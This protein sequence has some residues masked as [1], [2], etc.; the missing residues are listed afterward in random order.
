MSLRQL[1]IGAAAGSSGRMRIAADSRR[2]RW[3]AASVALGAAAVLL[4]TVNPSTPFVSDLNLRL[5]DRLLRETTKERLPAEFLLVGLD[6]ASL[7]LDTVEPEEIAQSRALQLMSQ[8]FPWSREVYA[9]VG[10]KL[11]EAGAKLVIFDMVYPGPNPGDGVFADFLRN[12][13]G[14]VVLGSLFEK[15]SAPHQP[16]T[17]RA[18]TA[19]LAAAAG[20]FIG[21]ASLTDQGE[22]RH[23]MPFAS[24]SDFMGEPGYPDE[25]V[26]RALTT[27]A[28]AALGKTFPAAIRRPLRFRYSVP[29]RVETVSL[30][31][32]FV[33]GYW[34]TNLRGGEIFRDKV[35][36]VGA[37]AEGLKDFHATPFGRLSG[38]EIQFHILAA[39]LRDGWLKSAG[40]GMAVVSIL[41]AAAGVLALA[42][43]RR[44]AGWF[45]FWLLA[46]ALL[47]GLLCLFA[48]VFASW[49]LPIA[50][51][52]V[53][54]L[55]CGFLVLACEAT[56]ER[57]ERLRLR[58]T[59]ERYFSKEVAREIVDNPSS[60][61]Q[62]LGG[63]RKE[64][65]AMFC[66]LHGFTAESETM[67]AG[68]MVAL[69]NE[70]FGDM[71]QVV[72]LRRGMLDKFM[73]DALM[74]TWGAMTSGG[75]EEDA[76]NALQ[77][78][79]D[80]Q[81]Q[82]AKLNER[83]RETGRPAWRT[84]I[85]ITQGEV[86]FGNIGCQEKMEITA[87]G[88]SVNLASR[89]EGLTRVYGCD[90]LID[91]RMAENVRAECPLL[92]VDVVRVK[93]RQKP[94]AL[95]FPCPGGG[96]REWLAAFE[97][98][99]SSYAHRAF[100]EAAEVFSRLTESGPAPAVAALFQR[101]CREFQKNPPPPDWSGVWDFTSK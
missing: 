85:G 86:V 92:L 88:D 23:V 44:S 25:K 27:V 84:G 2:F 7:S 15:P 77:A 5:Q 30:H 72:F 41:L 71:V 80:M 42:A 101:R 52:L 50:P 69:L 95:Y 82:L 9:L 98:A 75:P 28:A 36:I 43:R 33:P 17:Y 40:P 100:A 39:M 60:F 78:A 47:W 31:E 90:I 3:Q 53:T 99:R 55:V 51:P 4:L 67:D 45:L 10:Q 35:V 19:Q 93:G 61:F 54:W 34:Q 68:A 89:I 91:S 58:F 8:G 94:E 63:Q 12:N 70:Y 76:R 11:L 79:F 49:F 83:R 1:A 65:V 18:P 6:D 74:A 16:A 81:H 22:I 48:L 64:V 56:L 87:I 38:P 37:T 14:K 96:A 26:E 57:R 97:R 62:M 13:P 29:R 59:V 20:G 73:G 21:Y 66:D 32:I 24:L 46:G